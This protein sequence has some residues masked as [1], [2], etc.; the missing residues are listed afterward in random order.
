[1]GKEKKKG[2]GGKRRARITSFSSTLPEK[3]EGGEKKKEDTI[4]L[5][6][7]CKPK[8]GCEKKGEDEEEGKKGVGQWD[9]GD[10]GWLGGGN[11]GS[12]RAGKSEGGKKKARRVL[13][14]PSK[15]GENKEEKKKEPARW[16]ARAVDPRADCRGS[17]MFLPFFVPCRKGK[18]V[19]KKKEG[20]GATFATTIFPLLFILWKRGKKR[21]RGKGKEK[22]PSRPPFFFPS[23]TESPKGEKETEKRGGKRK[24]GRAVSEDFTLFHRNRRRR[25]KRKDVQGG[26]EKRKKKE[27]ED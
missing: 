18:K 22:R 15:R 9:S 7:P 27:E 14:A 6:I 19:E 8:R 17:T 11:S 16:P 20:K 12:V 10:E 21:L 5:S 2:L 3:G 23:I 24:G 26:K 13:A 4:L 1:V 25:K